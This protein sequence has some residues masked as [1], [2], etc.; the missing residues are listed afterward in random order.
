MTNR[1]TYPSS[2]DLGF[3][4]NNVERRTTTYSS[5]GMPSAPNWGTIVIPEDTDG[6]GFSRIV[7]LTIHSRNDYRFDCFYY[8]QVYVNGTYFRYYDGLKIP[9][10]TSVPV[11]TASDPL[12]F[13]GSNIWIQHYYSITPTNITGATGGSGFGVGYD[14]TVERYY[15]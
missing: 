10:G 11:I 13:N 2:T 12:Y 1:I 14:I 15:D 6:N 9:W 7:N 3:M 4:N 8:M 5:I